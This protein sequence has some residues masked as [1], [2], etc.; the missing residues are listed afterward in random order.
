VR[1]SFLSILFIFLIAFFFLPFSYA[2]AQEAIDTFSVKLLA[3]KN[4]KYKK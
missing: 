1:K 2:H 4:G 3:H